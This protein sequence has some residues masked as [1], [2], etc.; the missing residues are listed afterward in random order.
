LCRWTDPFIEETAKALGA[1]GVCP[2]SDGF[3]QLTGIIRRLFPF[4]V[5]PTKPGSL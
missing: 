1:A 2:T 3:G 4:T 5:A